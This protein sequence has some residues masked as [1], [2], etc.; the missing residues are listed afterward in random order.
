MNLEDSLRELNTLLLEKQ[1]K[2]FTASWIIEHTPKT[3]RAI[4]KHA[5][6]SLDN[7]DW[8]W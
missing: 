2:I 1:L 8:A 3:Y 6:T 4:C 7:I 5:R